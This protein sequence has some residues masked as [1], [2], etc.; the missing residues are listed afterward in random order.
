MV[1]RV[2]TK[3][4]KQPEIFAYRS[5]LAILVVAVVSLHPRYLIVIKRCLRRYLE[6]MERKM[7]ILLTCVH[8][9]SVL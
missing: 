8:G 5:T 1:T 2:F 6:R 9:V 7:C 4:T 3:I